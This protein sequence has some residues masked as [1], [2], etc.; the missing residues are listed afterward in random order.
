[1]KIRNDLAR[2]GAGPGSHGPTS[3]RAPTPVLRW[4]IWALGAALPLIGLFLPW[5]SIRVGHRRALT[6]SGLDLA[7]DDNWITGTGETL[8]STH[9]LYLIAAATAAFSGLGLL[10]TRFRSRSPRSG[11]STALMILGTLAFGVIVARLKNAHDI[12]EDV[13]VSL[14][15]RLG[16]QLSLVGMALLVAAG[17]LAY[18]ARTLQDSEARRRYTIAGFLGPAILLVLVFFFAP[19]LVLFLLS[20]TDLRGSNF[21]EPWTYIGF[22]NYR[23]VYGDP[24]RNRILGNTFRYVALTLAFNVLMGLVIAILTSF[25]HK[26]AGVAARA[27]WLLPRITPPVVYIVIWTRIGAQAPYGIVNQLASIFGTSPETGWV[28]E[29]PWVFVVLVNGFV[30]ASLAMLILSSAIE[31]IPRAHFMAAEVDGAGKWRITRDIMLP[32]L[33]WPLLF[34]VSYQTL[35]LLVSFE[36]I[37][38]LT[39]GGPGLFETE[40]WALTS[41]NRAIGSYFGSNL[42]AQGAAWGFILVGIGTVLSFIYL[43]I[44]RFRELVHEPPIEIV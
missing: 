26:A 20:L 32:Q 12:A 4:S 11:Q 30:G 14:E 38:L 19:V 17:F 15:S 34:V 27:L 43:R 7:L 28:N 6:V 41:Y 33:K 3:G 23:T 36:Y 37:L 24:F 10:T 40:V 39:G 18:R 29:Y 8:V 13:G 35:S 16:L 44:F 21:S 25:V 22:D 2:S 42:W 1:M 9:W 31:S 5:I